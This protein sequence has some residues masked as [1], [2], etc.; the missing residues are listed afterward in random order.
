MLTPVRNRTRALCN[1]HC[2]KQSALRQVH[3]HMSERIRIGLQEQLSDQCRERAAKYFVWTRSKQTI[4]AERIPQSK[5]KV[6]SIVVQPE[7][8]MEV[9][10]LSW[11]KAISGARIEEMARAAM[12]G[13]ISDVLDEDGGTL[14]NLLLDHKSGFGGELAGRV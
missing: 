3:L 14:A 13:V 12:N 5:D 1:E 4:K 10:L 9:D 2:L 8:N 7:A 11:R 6:R